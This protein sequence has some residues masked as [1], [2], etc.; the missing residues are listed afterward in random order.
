MD[1]DCCAQTSCQGQTYCRG[2]PDP[3]ATAGQ[4]QSAAGQPTSRGFYDRVSFLIGPSGSHVAPGE[5]P[6]NSSRDQA[7]VFVQ[8][9]RDVERSR[10]S[11]CLQLHLHVCLRWRHCRKLFT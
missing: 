7:P 9:R 5:N 6:F 2:S 10:S 4:G 8:P 3:T 11:L 1:P